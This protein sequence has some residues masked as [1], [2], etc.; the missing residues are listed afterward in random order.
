M[1]TFWINHIN[2]ISIENNLKQIKNI[3]RITRC[4]S[5]MLAIIMSMV[6]REIVVQTEWEEIFV[7]AI[8][9]DAGD[10]GGRNRLFIRTISFP[11]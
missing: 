6:E 9:W 1:A 2:N 11:A 3:K 7:N 10:A 8:F 4:E 5:E